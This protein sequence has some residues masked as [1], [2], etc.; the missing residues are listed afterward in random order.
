MDGLVYDCFDETENSITPYELPE[1]TK[2]Y[3]GVDFGFT[4]PFA[5]V[6]IAITPERDYFQ[7]TEIYKTGLTVLDM[8]QL[9]KQKMQYYPISMVYADPS[10]PGSIEEF[11]RAGI[12]TAAADNEIRRGIDFVYE[13]IKSKK[14]KLFRG[15]NKF[16]IDELET[17][18]YP[19][20]DEIKVNTNIEDEL[21]VKQSDHACDALRYVVSAT[22]AGRHRKLPQVISTLDTKEK[23]NI[24]QRA[25]AIYEPKQ[26]KFEEY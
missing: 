26:E 2:Y 18:H 10:S 1:G 22:Y 20:E 6:I 12:P 23:M 11:N 4:A 8:V 24:Y 13:L 5:V 15:D 17:Y 21:P 9:V 7:I 3:A 16:T 14:Y 25:K 19:S